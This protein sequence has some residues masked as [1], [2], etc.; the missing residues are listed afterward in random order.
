MI[1]FDSHYLAPSCLPCLHVFSRKVTSHFAARGKS[2]A[3][4]RRDPRFRDNV[5]PRA[6]MPIAVLQAKQANLLI[7]YAPS[8]RR[9]PLTR[10]ADFF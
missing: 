6:A 4:A 5:P 2:I 1:Y 7:F 9:A 3:A 8:H 10:R